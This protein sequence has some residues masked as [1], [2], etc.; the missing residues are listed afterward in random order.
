[1]GERAAGVRKSAR[2]RG[3]GEIE[4]EIELGRLGGE[5]LERN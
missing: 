3:T 4:V 1:M 2:N 5:R